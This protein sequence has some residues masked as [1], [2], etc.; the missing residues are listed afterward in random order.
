MEKYTTRVNVGIYHNKTAWNDVGGIA[1]FNRK[2]GCELANDGHEVTFYSS[3]KEEPHAE[4]D[5]PNVTVVRINQERPTRMFDRGTLGRIHPHVVECVGFVAATVLADVDDRID[6]EE[7]VLLT[8]TGFEDLLISQFVE[9]PVVHEYHSNLARVGIGAWIG[10]HASG[11]ALHL[12][13]SQTTADRLKSDLDIDVDG[14]VRP[15]VDTDE[16]TVPTEEPNTP[17]EIT[18]VGRLHE[19]KGIEELIRAFDGLD[20]DARLNIVG[21]GK[22]RARF[23]SLARELGTE[24]VTFHGKVPRPELPGYYH[25]A[26][27]ACHPSRHD[28][29]LITNVEAMATGIPVVT[30]DLPAILEY[31]VDG[32]NCRVTPVGDE[33][34]LRDV[35]EE[36]L[37][38]PDQRERLAE[39]G[40][41]TAERFDWG[42]QADEMLAQFERAIRRVGAED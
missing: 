31:A 40:R 4:L 21:E 28:S 38:S 26:T 32:E 39:A 27:I 41:A 6:R 11:A 12:A 16:F 30:T 42:N 33:D 24:D 36:L 37:S 22:H 18:F 9:T 1:V 20:A 3:M 14:I 5:R 25:R 17:P 35:M 8:G 10:Q 2:I 13:N 19:H 29:F 7:D 23:E 15:G 34:A